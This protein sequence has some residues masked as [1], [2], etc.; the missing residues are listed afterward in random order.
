M[1]DNIS[2]GVA[3]SVLGLLLNGTAFAGFAATYVQLHVGAPGASGTSNV[4][5]NNTRQAAG[6]FATPSGGSTTNSGAVNWTS[7][8]TNETYS[9][10][11][12]WSASTSGTF[13]ASGSITAGAILAGQNFTIPAG[14]MSVSLPVAA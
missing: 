13:I 3:N 5:G 8:P 1:A 2:S 6:A 14:G 4:A 11:S 7:V 12:L 10:V 9:H